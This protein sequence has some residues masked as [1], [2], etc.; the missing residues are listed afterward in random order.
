MCAPGAYL[1]S[2]KYTCTLNK[3]NDTLAK[4]DWIVELD[5]HLFAGAES[6]CKDEK[7]KKKT[8]SVVDCDG[9]RLVVKDTIEVPC[10]ASVHSCLNPLPDQAITFEHVYS[11]PGEGTEVLVRAYDIKSKRRVF[12]VESS[13]DGGPETEL[14][15]VEDVDGDGVPEIV[16]RI[17]G[18]GKVVSK[19]KWRN[20]HFVQVKP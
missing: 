17:A 2:E 11:M 12:A 7:K 19:M 20:R 6:A 16:Q 5:G 8:I 4:A 3:E 14:M 1:P 10:D 15:S 18:T 13:N 9:K